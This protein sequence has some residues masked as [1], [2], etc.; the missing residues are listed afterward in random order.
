VGVGVSVG[1]GGTSVGVGV[2]VGVDGTSVRAG[3]SVGVGETCTADRIGVL[4]AAGVPVEGT[5]LLADG[6]GVAFDAGLGDTGVVAGPAWV[7]AS[8]IAFT[9]ASRAGSSACFSV[10]L[11]ATVASM[12]GVG[13]GSGCCVPPH[14]ALSASNPIA[15]ATTLLCVTS[16]RKS[17]SQGSV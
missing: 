10:I 1:V 3:V 12:S 17:P 16:N 14:A 5:D 13:A 7:V 4:V 6:T 8:T 15:S 9:M 2:S 11:A